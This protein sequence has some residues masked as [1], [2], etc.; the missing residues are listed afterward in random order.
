MVFKSG[1]PATADS[2]RKKIN[3]NASVVL[4][5]LNVMSMVAED[6]SQ[7]LYDNKGNSG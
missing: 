3:F 7:E 5:D 4:L 6:I 2:K 1:M